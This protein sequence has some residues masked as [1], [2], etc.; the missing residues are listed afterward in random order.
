MRGTLL[1]LLFVARAA[2]ANDTCGVMV[3]Y[4]NT[5][6]SFVG[7]ESGCTPASA[8]TCLQGEMIQFSVGTFGY[9]FLC[10]A[11]RF[12]WDFGDGVTSNA[13][14]VNHMFPADGGYD[15]SV[16]ISTQNQSVVLTQ[17]IYARGV[18]QPARPPRRR[19]VG[20]MKGCPVMKP[21]INVFIQYTGAHTQCSP[22]AQT[23]CR[24]GEVVQFRAA[25]FGYQFTCS[26]HQFFWY[27]GDGTTGQG[28]QP[29]HVYTAS[30]FY[31]VTLS[32]LNEKQA[33]V[34]TQKVLAAAFTSDMQ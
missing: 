1:V 29:S 2:F 13:S 19:A 24:P 12:E 5:Y 9:S 31:M 18:A 21:D 8:S 33:V 28:A 6:I 23:P 26:P 16:R 27:F 22:V 7:M 20:P 32:I 10:A 17:R 3:P 15:V 11:H 14:S 34:V 4:M 25:S 30:G